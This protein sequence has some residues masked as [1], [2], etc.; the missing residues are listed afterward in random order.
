MALETLKG[1]SEIN[2]V[3]ILDATDFKEEFA[4]SDIH[5]AFNS[6]DNVL[7]FKI[8][9]GP[10][11]EVGHNGCQVSDVVAVCRH[12]FNELNKK[13]PCV[14]NSESIKKLDEVLYW[15]NKRTKDREARKVEGM[16]KV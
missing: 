5:I 2:G 4:P 8:Q 1:L 6:K 12:I 15:Q 16:N 7:S 13:F 11:K 10:I 14:E 9:N 3:K